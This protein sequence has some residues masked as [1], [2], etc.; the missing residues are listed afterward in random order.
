MLSFKSLKSKFLAY[1][2][3][4]LIILFLIVTI[5]L[6]NI[7]SNRSVQESKKGFQASADH[8]SIAFKSLDSNLHN[9]MNDFMRVFKSYLPYEYEIFPEEIQKVGSIDAPAFFN[10][11]VLLNNNFLPLE[12]FTKRTGVIATVFAR[13][14]DDFV[15]VSTTLEKDDGTRAFGTMLGNKSPALKPILNKETFYGKV[16]LFG[17][18]YYVVYE[19]IIEKGEV[20]GI[21]FIGYDFTSVLESLKEDIKKIKINEQGYAF[22]MDNKGTLLIHPSLEGQNVLETKDDQGRFTFKEMISGEDRFM[23]YNFKGEPKL[24]YVKHLKGFNAILV[25]TDGAEDVYSFSKEATMVIAIAFI[26][27]LIVITLLLVILSSK[28]VE[29][30]LKKLNDGLS[31]FFAF[32]NQE[33]SNVS[34]LEI[35]GEDEFAQ[36]ST[37]INHNIEQTQLLLSQDRALI[38]EVTTVVSKIKEG[39]FTQRVNSTTHN[40]SLEQLKNQLNEMLDVTSHNVCSDVNQLK[41]LL[42]KFKALDFTQ[43][44]K[45]DK[46][47]VAQGLN[48]LAEIINEML[49]E[50]KS[51]GIQL[52]KSSTQLLDNMSQLNDSTNDAAANLEET[53]AA[54]EQITGNIRQNSQ[55][56]TKMATLSQNVL[57]SA[58]DGEKLANET[59]VSMDDINEQVTLINEAISVIDQIAFQTNILSLNAAVEAA[60]AGE[61]GKGFAVVAQEVRNLAARSAE[62]AKE[63][64]EIV[65]NAT[66]K[67]TSGKEIASKMIEGYTTLNQN[68]TQTIDLISDIEMASKEQL[69]GIEQINDAVNSLDKQTQENAAI[70]N[71]TNDVAERANVIAKTVLDNAN[72]KEFIGKNDIK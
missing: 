65:E 31:Q 25:V 16:K 36:M 3:S 46:G 8:I 54:L 42:L 50:N 32:L 30:P 64:K 44:V 43:R 21:M 62:A 52:G 33:S 17:K 27:T 69:Q 29:T 34:A 9:V 71:Q 10:G 47:L 56:V 5:V 53:S 1:I 55:N 41:A 59:T 23:E 18:D 66:L 6:S 28:I 35:N 14:G 61:A 15:R 68:I 72:A 4:T 2:L 60:T 51:M 67:A 48:D 7:I 63:I 19:P 26:V 37:V 39:D 58:N 45:N 20:I 49:V 13:M 12:S 70:A 40:K 24:A 11:D 38:E 22:M 57:T